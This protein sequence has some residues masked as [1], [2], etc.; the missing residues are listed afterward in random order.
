MLGC[1]NLTT[2]AFR[3][4][5]IVCGSSWHSQLTAAVTTGSFVRHRSRGA[6]ASA[7]GRRPIRSIPPEMPKVRDFVPPDFDLDQG[8]PDA[9][10]AR[11]LKAQR[12]HFAK[13]G[14]KG[15]HDSKVVKERKVSKKK[16]AAAAAVTSDDFD[17]S[18]TGGATSHEKTL[19]Q[20][21]LPKL[22]RIHPWETKS[23]YLKPLRKIFARKTP[24]SCST[25]EALERR[26]REEEEQF[27]ATPESA[28]EEERRSKR[29][30]RKRAPVANKDGDDNDD[31]GLLVLEGK[32]LI[33]EAM[34]LGIDPQVLITSRI[35]LLQNFPLENVRNKKS[36]QLFLVP[37]NT[38][39]SWSD[40]TTS[41]GF[42]AAFR[43]Q[44]I[45]NRA[46]HAKNDNL[47]MTLI[48]DNVR[49]PDNFGGILRVA[50]AA[51]CRQVIA[52]AGCVDP[53]QPKVLR[54]AGGAHFH[55]DIQSKALWREM[56]QFLP[57]R[58][59]RQVVMCNMPTASAA[60]SSA[61]GDTSKDVPANQLMELMHE[62]QSFRCE[63]PKSG[64]KFDYSFDEPELVNKFSN[65][66]LPR[67][68]LR[69][70]TL[71]DCISEG[72]GGR[73]KHLVLMVG[74][75]TEG[76]S[77]KGHKFVVE[78][79]GQHAYLPLFNG[80]ESL[81]VLSAASILLYHCQSQYLASQQK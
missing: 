52:T 9:F 78:N 61:H 65:V 70:C 68:E 79:S 14:T 23:K 63:D 5:H 36:I 10:D 13:L 21:G 28:E 56:D 6:A 48:L 25:L 44:D 80:M 15:Q 51:G 7:G 12:D 24:T 20:L 19:R 73:K 81:N 64:K 74:G 54:A 16:S 60:G 35:S 57:T 55:L 3:G 46:R 77:L 50:A 32:R 37:Y 49:N 22:I 27:L 30:E 40:L 2:S 47:P 1:R 66:C 75:E 29:S 45:V 11:D 39:S 38:L 18:A 41:P 58:Q 71:E 26:R 69:D 31:D 17:E 62:C 67:T 53:W 33:I 76:V 59:D 42:A 4:V 43:K 34:N 72:G 8:R